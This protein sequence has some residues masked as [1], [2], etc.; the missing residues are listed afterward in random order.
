M[1]LPIS[2]EQQELN[3]AVT[4]DKPAAGPR[5]QL[6]YTIKATDYTGKGVRAEIG[7][8]LV[9]KAVLSLI[10]DPNSSLKQAF[11]TKRPL[12]VFTAPSLTALVDRVTLKLQP[13]DKGG[14]G[15]LA[16]EVL[17]RRNFPDTAYW[18][19]SV[20]T[21][22]DGTAKVTLTLP[23]SLTTWRMTARGLTADTRVGQTTADLIATKPLL[24]RPSL[25]RFLTVGDKL[26]LQAVVQNNTANPIDATVTIDTGAAAEGAAQ[27]KLSADAEQSVQVPAN[28]S[29]VVRWPAEVTGAGQSTM[30][31]SVEGGGLQDIVEQALPVQRYT[32]PEVVATAGQV[33]D[34]IVETID[35]PANAAQAPNGAT[36]GELDLELAPSLAAGID[37]ALGYLEHYPYFCSEQTVSRF[38]P[39]AATYRLYKQLGMDDPKLKASLDANLVAG[40][41][42]LYALQHLDGGWGW[43]ENDDSQPYLT[44]YVVQGL[45]EARKAG[46]AVDQ[47]RF[48]QAIGYLKGSLENQEPTTDKQPAVGS[49]F[50]ILNSRSYVLFVLAEAGQPDRGRSVALYDQRERLDIYGRAYL[51]M[52]LKG[53][54]GNDERV[55]ALVGELMS[56]AIM[57]AADAHWEEQRVDYWNMSSDTRTTAL[58]LEA[59]LRADPTNYLIPNA[60]RYLMGQRDQGHWRTTQESAITLIALSEYIAQS[61][62][63]EADY[64]YRAALDSKTLKEGTVNRD[65]LKDP[66]DVVVALADLKL[67]DKSQLTIQRQAANGQT[68]KGRLYYTLRMRYYQDAA[69]VQ[70]LDQ[71]VGVQREYIAVASDTLS[72]TGQLIDQARLSDVVQVRLTLIVPEDMQYF[73]VEDMLPAG[74]EPLD[75]SLKTTSAAARGAELGPA[76][77]P[78][79]GIQDDVPYW[80]Y[81]NQTSIHDNRVALFAT[82]LPKGTYHYT[83]L[84]RATNAGTFQTLPATAYQMYAPEVF[85]RSAGA[86]FTVTGQ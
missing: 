9:D 67:G 70:P 58:A 78:S 39:N 15:G 42:R 66:I 13:G 62:E 86:A 12:A 73:A 37:S 44:A 16:S 69:S 31:F 11:Y 10:D 68:G 6:T 49:Q 2:T 38:L 32:T 79:P 55:H 74:L 1:N 82:F 47:A 5:D 84:A 22:D 3:I 57:H 17:V 36:Q 65:N 61:G 71:G 72:P 80:W 43:W 4:P 19:P 45:V 28:S 76:E 48:D 41:Q 26:T 51:L 33:L 56:T 23:D 53:L 35:A 59:L 18:N 8:A 34:T 77:P 29:A 50:S 60:V 24:V 85:G 25:P 63:L 14:G 83:Y 7:L 54:G 81:F 21:A 52:T 40:L 75:A 30:R 20:T 64:S 46:Y 27:L